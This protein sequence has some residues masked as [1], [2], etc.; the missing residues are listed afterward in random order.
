MAWIKLRDLLTNLQPTFQ[1]TL[2]S[3]LRESLMCHGWGVERGRNWRMDESG[4]V[5]VV[6]CPLVAG[7][8]R[9]QAQVA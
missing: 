3:L 8:G 5:G 9:G 7:R 1:K 6:L 4:V 2:S